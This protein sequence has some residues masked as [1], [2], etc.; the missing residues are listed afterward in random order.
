VELEWWDG[1]ATG[2]CHALAV[3]LGG[4]VLVRHLFAPERQSR[5]TIAPPSRNATSE[6]LELLVE[7][8]P[9]CAKS[10]GAPLAM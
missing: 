4:R 7:G 10:E 8:S 5:D 1:I 6:E 2:G 3:A 9:W